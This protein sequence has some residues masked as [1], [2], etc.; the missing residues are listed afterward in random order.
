M[1]ITFYEKFAILM[2]PYTFEVIVYDEQERPTYLLY[3][4]SLNMLC[5][6]SAFF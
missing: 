6:F 1:I 5:C 3:L 4:F 2:Y